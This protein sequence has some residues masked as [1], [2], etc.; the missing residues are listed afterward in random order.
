MPPVLLEVVWRGCACLY[1]AITSLCSNTHPI[2]A[3]LFACSLPLMFVWAL[4]LWSVVVCV[5]DC[6][7]L[8]IDSSII[9]S[10]WLLCR[11]GCFVCVFRRYKTLKQFVKMCAGSFRY[12]VVRRRRVWCMAINSARRIFWTPGNRSAILRFLKGLYIPY[13]VFS[14]FQCLWVISLGGIN[15]QSV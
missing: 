11:V 10:G 1:V 2:L 14:R 5:R 3:N 12:V 13:H 6:N 15:D 4:T 9:L 8:I 7:I